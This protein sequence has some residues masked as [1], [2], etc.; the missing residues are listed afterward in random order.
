MK[1]NFHKIGQILSIIFLVLP[2]LIQQVHI[3]RFTMVPLKPLSDQ[4]CGRYRRFPD[5]KSV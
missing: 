3:F 1:E 2:A 5:L 4:K